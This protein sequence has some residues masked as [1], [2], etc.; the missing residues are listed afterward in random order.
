MHNYLAAGSNPQGRI[1]N[2]IF[3]NSNV[4][5][6]ESVLDKGQFLSIFIPR[7]VGIT[8]VVGALAFFFMFLWGAVNW[9]LSGGDKAHVESAK[10]RITNAIVGFILMVGV[11]AIIKLIEAFFGIDILL[12]DIGSLVIQ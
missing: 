1:T 2:P 4:G 10:G 7:F 6:L 5:L 9:I 12:I 3:S 11:F 8:F